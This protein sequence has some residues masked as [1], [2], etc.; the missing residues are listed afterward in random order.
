MAKGLFSAGTFT[1]TQEIMMAKGLFSAGI[2]G[3]ESTK[4]WWQRASLALEPLSRRIWIM[5]AKNLFLARIEN[6]ISSRAVWGTHG[7]FGATAPRTP[8]HMVFRPESNV[9]V[10]LRLKEP[11]SLTC[12][13][14][15]RLAA[16]SGPDY[17]HIRPFEMHSLLSQSNQVHSS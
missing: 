6:R 17:W 5:M 3:P 7:W 12:C 8:T 14:H 9:G 16:Q 2:C 13:L 4:S 1:G 10:F 11:G 15:A